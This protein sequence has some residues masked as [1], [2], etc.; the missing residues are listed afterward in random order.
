MACLCSLG[1]AISPGRVLRP[2]CIVSFCCIPA[3]LFTATSI[4]PDAKVGYIYSGCGRAG[5]AIGPRAHLRH[6]EEAL[7]R[8][9][10]MD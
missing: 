4:A 1:Q 6:D 10:D 8:F 5:P 7:R 3:E 9:Q 2:C